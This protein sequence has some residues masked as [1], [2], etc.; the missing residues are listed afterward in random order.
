MRGAQI[1]IYVALNLEGNVSAGLAAG[2]KV[3]AEDNP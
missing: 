2:G 1:F 3:A